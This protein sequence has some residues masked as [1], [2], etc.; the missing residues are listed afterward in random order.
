[1][2]GLPSTRASSTAFC[3][4]QATLPPLPAVLHLPAAPNPLSPNPS[5]CFSKPKLLTLNLGS[6]PIFQDCL[7][8]HRALRVLR[9]A[10][11]EILRLGPWHLSHQQLS[12]ESSWTRA[13]RRSRPLQGEGWGVLC[14]SKDA[15]SPCFTR[16]QGRRKSKA[17]GQI[18]LP[19]PSCFLVLSNPSFPQQLIKHETRR[20]GAVP[21]LLWLYVQ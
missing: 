11:P 1:M 8:R 10:S 13:A 6:T 4:S 19:S 17:R 12:A 14:T 7:N 2:A 9:K 5:S 3:L 21:H 15:S 20:G 16:S 18:N